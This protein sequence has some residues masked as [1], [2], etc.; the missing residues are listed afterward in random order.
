M[1][2]EEGVDLGLALGLGSR[3]ELTEL[4]ENLIGLEMNAFDLVIGTAPFDGR[5]VHDGGGGGA[6]GVAHV[7]FV[8]STFS[9]AKAASE[10]RTEDRCVKC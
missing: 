5:P 6:E 9:S 10:D 4:A 7:R 3:V 2:A 1:I 8:K